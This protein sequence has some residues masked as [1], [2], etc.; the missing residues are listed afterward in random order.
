VDFAWRFLLVAY[1]Y[2]TMVSLAS[3]ALEEVAFHRYHRWR[4]LWAA[5][6]AA[7]L[8]NLGYRQVIAVAQLQG[9]WAALRGKA[10]VWGVMTREG[11]G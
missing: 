2:A 6:L 11:I 7:L 4:D 5:V 3:L 10:P 9:A 8:E 1:G